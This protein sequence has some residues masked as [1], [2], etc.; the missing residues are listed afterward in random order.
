MQPVFWAPCIF[1]GRFIE[2]SGRPDEGTDGGNRQ[3]SRHQSTMECSALT[4]TPATFSARGKEA[5]WAN[6]M[7]GRAAARRSPCRKQ[8]L[9]AVV[10]RR[11]TWYHCALADV[12]RQTVGSLRNSV[13]RESEDKE[14]SFAHGVDWASG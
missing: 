12:N 14:D 8:H 3:N 13:G 10:V 1:S 4:L 11:V 6:H 5:V 2:E 7:C 9:A